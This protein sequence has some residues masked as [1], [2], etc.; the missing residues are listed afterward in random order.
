MDRRTLLRGAALAA[1]IGASALFA[2]TAHAAT[3]NYRVIVT[4]QTTNKVYVFYKDA[5]FS[6][7][8]AYKTFNPG[9][10]TGWVNL[11]DVR[12]RNTDAFG[13][14]GL[15][16]G[17]G[18]RVGIWNI[19]S[20]KNAGSG[21]ILWYASP[22]DNPH[23]LERIPNVGAYVAASSTPGKLSV[24][25]PTKVADPSTLAL[26]QTI[27]LSGARGVLWDPDGKLLWAAAKNIVRA[28]TVSGTG[29]SVR[30]S[31]AKSVSFDG[32]VHD[33]QPDYTNTGRLLV[34]DT[35]GAYSINKSSL[36]KSTLATARRY[37]SYFK[38]TSGETVW[39]QGDNVEPRPW[40]STTV[41]FSEST[42][43]SRSGAR[44]YKARWYATRYN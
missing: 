29:R 37:K 5:A 18:G 17:S 40:G 31:S 36:A 26:V 44:F 43:R 21:S 12:I 25:G 23:A 7:A 2:G 20:T 13:A 9:S 33:I 4:E 41:R 39:I 42:N 32:N 28:Y 16:A 8:N 6:D 19:T 24:Y 10:A 34:T 30:L 35:Y 14:I 38:H 22:G 15:V 27:N 3:P 1:P 11:S